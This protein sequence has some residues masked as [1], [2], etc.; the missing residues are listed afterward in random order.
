MLKNQPNKDEILKSIREGVK[1]AFLEMMEAK[2][3]IRTKEVMQSIE[4]GVFHAFPG[5]DTDKIYDMQQ[6]KLCT[7]KINTWL[8]K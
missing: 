6:N 1:E 4:D 2:D 8:D 5:L 7:Q 3:I